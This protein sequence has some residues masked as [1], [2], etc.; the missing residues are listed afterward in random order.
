MPVPVPVATMALR[1]R[2][3]R[4][5]PRVGRGCGV[6]PLLTAVVTCIATVLPATG[7]A[8]PARTVT[9]EV[10]RRRPVGDLPDTLARH[11]VLHDIRHE[12]LNN[13]PERIY[14]QARETSFAHGAREME[15]ECRS[16]LGTD[17][18][19]VHGLGKCRRGSEDAQ[20]RDESRGQHAMQ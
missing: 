9:R 19:D 12:W 7:A 1:G 4:R 14:A 3:R 18:V 15:V 6:A 10:A 13:A 2:C 16:D 5:L 8:L 17:A 20:A 11:S